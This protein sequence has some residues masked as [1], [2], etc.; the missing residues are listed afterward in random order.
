[1]IPAIHMINRPD[2]EERHRR[3]SLVLRT[4]PILLIPV[5]VSAITIILLQVMTGTL[6]QPDNRPLLFTPL[7]P[8]IVLVV[9]SSA[10]IILVRL[11]RPTIS[12]LILIGSWTFLTTAIWSR[13]GVS[14]YFPALMILP[15]CAA[16]L[17]IDRVAS[18]SLGMLAVV[19]VG[20][21][22][23]LEVQGLLPE[24][25][26]GIELFSNL[27]GP[28]PAT[29]AFAFWAGLFI[30]VAGLTSLLAGGLQRALHQSRLQAEELRQLSAQLE[31]RVAS[32]TAQILEQEREAAILAERT[33]LAREIHDTIAQGLS[34]I[35]LQLGAAQRALEV[36]PAEARE[37]LDIAGGM[38]R[39]ALAEA[40]RS[41]WN[42]RAPALDYGDIGDALQGLAARQSRPEYHVV[43]TQLGNPR[44]LPVQI[45]G[46]LL[47]L[48][49]ES[50][51][52]AQRHAQATEVAIV[53][54]YAP[55]HISLTIRDNGVGFG[56]T[57]AH[58]APP[59]LGSGFGLAGMRERLTAIGG[60]LEYYDDG[61]A[62][63]SA[64]IPDMETT[65]DS[66]PDR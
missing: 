29:L 3:G 53:L 9:F 33:R 6:P 14:S 39:E 40:R 25:P 7:I 1:M 18:I 27:V 11:G 34:G 15:I 44:P 30:S 24:R 56:A 66:H 20:S 19:L 49:Q 8:I 31:D 45:E 42:L 37:Y 2:T 65:H 21:V 47:R 23:W 51:A 58:G 12:A 38:T 61:G 36:A 54:E 43:Y 17:L 16:G 4:L 41:V 10:L 57:M 13:A 26:A 62:V 59:P 22:A 28:A 52:N 50:L 5:M 64:T 55:T 60:A 32:Q 46:T 63:V 35:A 48:A